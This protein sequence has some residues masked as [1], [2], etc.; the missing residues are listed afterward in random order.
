MFPYKSNM[1]PVPK[2]RVKRKNDFFSRNVE[3]KPI[4]FL[5]SPNNLYSAP[6]VESPFHPNNGK[7]ILNR[8]K[9]LSSFL[10]CSRLLI[11]FYSFFPKVSLSFSCSSVASWSFSF[12]GTVSLPFSVFSADS[13]TLCSRGYLDFTHSF[14]PPLRA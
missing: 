12:F 6:S 9:M 10:C 2:Y 4:I 3:I 13:R 8:V 14:H 5:R 1:D 11:R 7:R